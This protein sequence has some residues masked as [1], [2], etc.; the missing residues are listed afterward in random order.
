M[1]ISVRGLV[2]FILREGDLDDRR[3]GGSEQNL[4]NGSRIHRMIQRRQGSGYQAEVPLSLVV[5][6]EDYA[7]C[8]EGRA[9]GILTGQADPEAAQ[10]KQL[11]FEDILREA[12]VPAD[13]EAQIRW[14]DVPVI[15]EIKSTISD[16]ARL[17]EART[18]DLAQAKCYA[19]FYAVR[20][21]LERVRV[22]MTYCQAQTEE[23]RYFRYRYTAD[24]LKSFFEGLIERYKPFADLL[25][26]G[27]KEKEQSIR[28]LS[29]PFPYRAGQRALTGYVYRT[30]ANGR[31][32]FLEAPTGAGKTLA[33]LYPA[34]KAVGEGHAE[35]IFYMTAK[36]V[37][38]TVPEQA[39]SILRRNGLRFRTVTLT[40][41]ERSCVLSRPSCNPDA[42]PRARGHYSHVND[43]LFDLLSGGEELNRE[44]ILAGA[45]AHGVCPFELT[46]DL[47][48]F[49]DG[50]ICDYNYV[51]DPFVYLRRF[52]AEG[53]GA[54]RGNIFLVD[55]AHNLLDRGREMYSAVITADELT[56]AA[57]SFRSSTAGD[58]RK[59]I[60]EK[61][62]HSLRAMELLLNDL[63]PGRLQ[64]LEQTEPLMSNL[65]GLAEL[66]SGLMDEEAE[67][68]G[69]EEVSFYFRLFRFLTIAELV[70]DHYVVYGE[71]GWNR[72]AQIKLMCV[73][74]AARLDYCMK[75]AVSTI[76][77]SA[78][79]LPIQYY[80]SLLGGQEEDYEAYAE[81]AFLPAQ[82]QVLLAQDVTTR[83]QERGDGQ[84]R[85]IARYLQETVHAKRGNYLVFFPS[86]QLLKE[87]KK[88]YLSAFHD[89]EQVQLVT[90][91]EQMTEEGREEFLSWFT[92]GTDADL[93]TDIRMDIE[94]TEEKS[95]LGLCVLGGIFGEGIDL[96]GERL[97]GVI[98]VGTGLPQV[99]EE[100]ELLRAWFDA[101][102][103]DGFDYAYRFPGMNKVLQALG[104]LIRT[105]E[106][107][108]V[109]LLL[110]ERFRQP[111][112]RRL[113]PREWENCKT[114]TTDSVKNEL[115]AFWSRDFVK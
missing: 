102:E 51:F 7:I 21:G 73:D 10:E 63:P 90:Q 103:I 112:Y 16:I 29:F 61:F 86:Y 64:V 89:P 30:I 1:R 22:R 41:K 3:R 14:E 49:A 92:S 23:I 56:A 79:L 76:L 15:D 95:V 105:E 6:Y 104:R 81:T 34:L 12:S 5:N 100:R 11:D 82:F 20:E 88:C 78:T 106:D 25:Y 93:T 113:F 52:F 55:E 8:V 19:W 99:G 109:I 83:Y 80:K 32:L 50:I 43:A 85:K 46:L 77:F 36:T 111:A 59:R 97:I 57:Q 65:I 33:V 70:D 66:I 115:N 39:F 42:C 98:V 44:T 13:Q 101:R 107:R 47:T 4:L 40:S 31:K 17:R 114:V 53:A 45:E 18:P 26:Y 54:G 72:R 75:R 60:Q 71:R 24:E 74:P 9:D 37:A 94:V 28:A 68:R 27:R 38:R 48:L 2:E 84:Y 87:V 69:D 67:V 110:D 35:R 96:R 108:G 58:M 62:D 91:Q